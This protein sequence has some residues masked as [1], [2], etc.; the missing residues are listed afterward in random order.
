[1]AERPAKEEEKSELRPPP[2]VILT[3]RHHHHYR[4]ILYLFFT[5]VL[6]LAVYVGWIIVRAFRHWMEDV[7]NF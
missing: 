6:A 4:W 1:V 7:E 3:P 5:A 2:T